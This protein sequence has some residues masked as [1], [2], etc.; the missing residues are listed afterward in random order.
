MAA[1]RI[2]QFF[3]LTPTPTNI[4][5][6]CRFLVKPTGCWTY[7]QVWLWNIM[8]ADY[9]AFMCFVWLSEETL[10]FTLRFINRL[11]FI[12]EVESVFYAVGPVSLYKMDTFRPYRF[13]HIVP[14]Y[15]VNMYPAP[16]ISDQQSLCKISAEKLAIS[17]TSFHFITGNSIIDPLWY[18]WTCRGYQMLQFHWMDAWQTA[19]LPGDSFIVSEEVEAA[20]PIEV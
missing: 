3:K 15:Y 17:S 2:I 20:F 14:S 18:S 1:D 19:W 4:F 10:T 13:K 6:S 16:T 11:V 7:H 5:F 12:T 9:I 8:H